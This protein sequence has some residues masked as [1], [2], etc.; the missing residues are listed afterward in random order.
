MRVHAVAVFALL[1]VM[2][3]AAA[4]ADVNGKWVGQMP[5]RDGGTI[6]QTF[7][8][9]NEGGKITGTMSMEFG[10]QTMEQKIVDGKLEGENISFTTVAEFNGNEFRMNYKGTVAGNQMKLIRTREGGGMGGG[11]GRGG[12]QEIVLKKVN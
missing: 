11:G 4:A 3:F 1:L 2:A 7:L 10:G 9:K 8:L 12:P 6:E 5:G